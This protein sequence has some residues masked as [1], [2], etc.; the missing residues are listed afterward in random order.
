MLGLGKIRI[1]SGLGILVIRVRTNDGLVRITR[2]GGVN[3]GR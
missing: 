2:A 1:S 3:R